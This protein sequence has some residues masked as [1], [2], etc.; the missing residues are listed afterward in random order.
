M[1]DF[2]VRGLLGQTIVNCTTPYRCALSRK[3]GGN[4][5]ASA[6]V[7]VLLCVSG[8]G[9][10]YHPG[11]QSLPQPPPQYASTPYQQTGAPSFPHRGTPVLRSDHQWPQ[12]MAPSQ[13]PLAVPQLGPMASQP[14]AYPHFNQPWVS[15]SMPV[16]APAPTPKQTGRLQFSASKGG[17]PAMGAASGQ[18]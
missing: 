11:Q 9:A 17:E 3:L 1:K 2:Y 12:Q 14:P 6:T 7:I 16:F 5:G 18:C 15:H 8:S 10:G 13:S 4:G